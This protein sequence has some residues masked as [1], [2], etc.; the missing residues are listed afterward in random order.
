HRH[1]PPRESGVCFSCLAA[2]IDCRVLGIGCPIDTDHFILEYIDIPHH[3]RTRGEIVRA[4]LRHVTLGFGT[5]IAFTPYFHREDR[6]ALQELPSRSWAYV[7]SGVWTEGSP[8]RQVD[9]KSSV[10][11]VSPTFSGLASVVA[12]RDKDCS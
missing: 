11:S 10:I 9:D 7:K 5:V 6:C 12:K 8:V 3:K 1:G 2:M 4:L